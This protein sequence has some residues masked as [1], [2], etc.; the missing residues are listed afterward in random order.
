MSIHSIY[1]VSDL[2]SA[3]QW[4]PLIRDN[5]L[6]LAANSRSSLWHCRYTRSYGTVSSIGLL[7][8]NC[9]PYMVV[10]YT[11]QYIPLPTK[12]WHLR[13]LIAHA[14]NTSNQPAV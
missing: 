14:I 7:G 11:F 12:P 8:Q 5:L 13:I 6:Q 1:L 3:N 4:R 10:H 2:R 9:K